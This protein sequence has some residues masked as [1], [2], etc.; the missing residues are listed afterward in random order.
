M[1]ASAAI[2][3]IGYGI[4]KLN[5]YNNR[6][7]KKAQDGTIAAMTAQQDLANP[8]PLP[9]PPSAL[10]ANA[11]AGKAMTQAAQRYRKQ[12]GGG[13]GSTLLTGGAGD[14]SSAPT[15]RKTALGL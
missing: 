2:A 3:S 5:D 7:S 1:G 4:K 6:Q 10:T 8:P 11:D 12:K 15:T 13:Y 14:P 9:P